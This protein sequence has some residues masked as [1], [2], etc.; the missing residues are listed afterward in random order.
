MKKSATKFRILSFEGKDLIGYSSLSSSFSILDSKENVKYSLFTG[1]LD[2]CLEIDKL[3]K[4]YKNNMKGARLRFETACPLFD[5]PVTLAFIN[6][7]FR[8]TAK[9]EADSSKTVL[10]RNDIRMKLYTDGFYVDGIH[11][12][13]YKRSAGSSRNGQC[14][15][16]PE[17]MFKDM[18]E[19]SS[20][21]LNPDLIK[22]LTS[23]EAY[24]SLTLS[25]IISTVTIS[26]ESVLILKDAFSV[27]KD[28]VIAVETDEKDKSE[29]TATEKET[30]ITNKIWDG[31]ALLDESVFSQVNFAEKGMMLLR[32]RFFKS[33][34]FNTNLQQF[35]KDNSI[36]LKDLKGFTLAKDISEIKLVVTD[37]SIKYLKMLG[38]G[39]ESADKEFNEGCKKWLKLVDS[40]YGIVKTEKETHHMNGDMVSANYQIINT[41]GLTEEEIKSLLEPSLTYIGNVTKQA[42][43]MRHYIKLK[44]SNSDDAANDSD[45]YE[46][47]DEEELSLL[48][49]TFETVGKML[50]LNDD[51][52][53][54]EYYKTFK[55]NV[56]NAFKKK[57][58]MGRI[59]I[60]GTY[61]T[62]FG[63]GIELLFATVGK[64]YD[65]DGKVIP[66]ALKNG[67]IYCK[68]FGDG[69]LLAA[70]SPHITMGNIFVADNKQSELYDKY[71]HLTKE[72]VC[73]NAID[74]N[75]QQRLNGCD[76]DSDTM[77][78][79]NN[80]TMLHAA[81]RNY[82]KF[83]V[84]SC[85]VKE[86]SDVAYTNDSASKCKMDKA[87][88]ENKIGEIV[89]L[90][91]LLNSIYWDEINNGA[92]Y[93]DPKQKELY[94][95]ICT[96]AAMSGMEID[97]AKRQYCTD[98]NKVLN[99]LSS[100]KKKYLKNHP[101]PRFYSV[102]T[103]AEISKKSEIKTSMEFTYNTVYDTK[104]VHSLTSDTE[105]DIVKSVVK[106]SDLISDITPKND[107]NFT[108]NVRAIKDETKK[109]KNELDEQNKNLH[110]KDCF[111]ASEI[112]E[113]EKQI[114]KDYFEFVNKKV[115]S[116]KV[117]LAIIKYLD[118]KEKTEPL[119]YKRLLFSALVLN[120]D[121]FN[122]HVK[123]CQNEMYDLIRSNK[124]DIDIYGYKHKKDPAKRNNT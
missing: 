16:I 53:G 77:L 102:I 42:I 107:T 23:F 35:F 47:N 116:D 109:T 39:P 112:R 8:Y 52:A 5:E 106:Y 55:N 98:S 2:N 54:T 105:K 93:D 15:F 11:Y 26:K 10:N 88:S 101:L 12:V 86:Q 57:L 49:Y 9:D 34:A 61:A 58:A 38:L 13:R 124:G 22:D 31:E 85:I 19:W 20:M 89:N 97:K 48:D 120:S 27:F 24:I 28:T 117:L 78:I 64:C 95:A 121:K 72:I 33:C 103:D 118:S 40:T 65:E 70:R 115:N 67:E 60:D 6:V 46:Q 44:L 56:R 87:I 17:P 79:T 71:F 108:K 41:L 4:S 25:S 7:T 99:R 68:R 3:R 83:L 90:S 82:D 1:I 119:K 96:L 14:L 81:I 63:N 104:Y 51:F 36:T 59:L 32:N 111:N 114:Y 29:I 92:S 91:Q 43:Y 69:K 80:P 45:I 94:S 76:Y 74:F 100:Y 62:L 21:D 18:M 122:E 73:I 84:P 113:K 66:I 30:T 75:I 50:L 110:K 123:K 37:S